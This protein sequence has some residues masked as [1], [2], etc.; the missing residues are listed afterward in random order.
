MHIDY[1]LSYFFSYDVLNPS[2]SDSRSPASLSPVRRHATE[3][4]Y[5]RTTIKVARK[6]VSFN[7]PRSLFFSAIATL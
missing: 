1:V 4:H 5:I 6:V 2:D 7:F 3:V